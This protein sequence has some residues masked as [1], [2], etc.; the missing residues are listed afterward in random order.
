[1]FNCCMTNTF[2]SCLPLSDEE[3]KAV[4]DTLK[5]PQGGCPADSTK[6]LLNALPQ[7]TAG[8]PI[9]QHRLQ[10]KTRSRNYSMGQQGKWRDQQH[11]QVP[12][13]CGNHQSKNTVHAKR[14]H[15]LSKRSLF[16]EAAPSYPSTLQMW[17]ESPEKQGKKSF[18]L[19]WAV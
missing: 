7:P 5:R 9:H 16:C 14:I 13:V 2:Q 1:M 17:K 12:S 11:N 18:L 8:I 3:K 4:L 6:H 19:T 15:I 10:P